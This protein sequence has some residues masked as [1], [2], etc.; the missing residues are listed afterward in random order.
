LARQEKFKE[1][2]ELLLASLAILKQE[3]GSRSRTVYIDLTNGYLADLYRN[4]GKS[5]QAA[6]YIS[7]S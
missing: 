3:P 2:E 7:G 1:A 5:A 6:K 4:W